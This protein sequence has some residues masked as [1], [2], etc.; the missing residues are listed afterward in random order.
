MWFFWCMVSNL[1]LYSRSIFFCFTA[2]NASCKL[3]ELTDTGE[4]AEHLR[5]WVFIVFSEQSNKALQLTI[6]VL[7]IPRQQ[8]RTVR[9][10]CI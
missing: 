10:S 3:A 9:R 1:Y 8:M 2:M 6:L 5:Q 4:P 7:M